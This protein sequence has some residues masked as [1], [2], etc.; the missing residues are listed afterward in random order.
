MIKIECVRD[1][2]RQFV[3]LFG[4]RRLSFSVNDYATIPT[5]RLAVRVCV[6]SSR[7]IRVLLK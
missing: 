5:L 7:Y 3:L 6:L 2:D 1:G 4:V